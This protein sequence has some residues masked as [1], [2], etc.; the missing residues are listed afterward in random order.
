MA[1]FDAIAGGV[2]AIAGGVGSYLGG[3]AAAEGAENA[4]AIQANQ[5]RQTRRDYMPWLNA[6]RGA[7]NSLNDILLRGGSSEYLATPGYEFRFK[8]GQRALENSASARNGVENGATMRALME[9]GQGIGSDEYERRLSRLGTLAGFGR[10]ALSTSSQLGAN[11]A[12][13]Q[14]AGIA[15]AGAIRGTSYANIANTLLGGAQNA[16]KGYFT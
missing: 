15:D 13:G 16:Y 9:Y 3:Q 8:E 1:L 2:G 6:G 7:I 12:A 11:A 4:A 10:D 5:Y 14:A